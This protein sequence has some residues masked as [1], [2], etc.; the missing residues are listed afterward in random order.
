MPAAGTVLALGVV[1]RRRARRFTYRVGEGLQVVTSRATTRRLD[2][3]SNDLPTARR[4]Q[5]VRV[6]GAQV[7]AVWLH[8]GG[9][10]AEDGCRVG[11]DVRER[12]NGGLP[13]SGTGTASN[14]AHSVRLYA[15][16]EGHASTVP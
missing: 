4:G 9:E 5:S 7:V 15:F 3:K 2:R 16:G 10:W 12:E 1:P 8:V 14:M 13:A 6:R 11:V